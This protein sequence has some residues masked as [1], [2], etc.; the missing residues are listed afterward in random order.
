LIEAVKE[1]IE[2][3]KR[4]QFVAESETAAAPS[5]EPNNHY[6]AITE[7]LTA[8]NVADGIPCDS[9]DQSFNSSNRDATITENLTADNI[10]YG[11]P[12]N[13]NEPTFLIPKK[14]DIRDILHLL[15]NLS[16]LQEIN[17]EIISGNAPSGDYSA[18]E[19][20]PAQDEPRDFSAARL[21]Y[22]RFHP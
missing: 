16:M 6:A 22:S 20:R 21:T 11:Q 13:Y 7:D 14:Q 19:S 15:A 5:A 17:S 18:T 9:N 2:E 1:R 3:V 4:G 12:C 8:D 10:A